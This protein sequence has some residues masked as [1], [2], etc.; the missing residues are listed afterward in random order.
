MESE[1]EQR[2][3]IQIHDIQQNTALNQQEKARALQQVMMGTYKPVIPSPT[4]IK[5]GCSHYRR[6]CLIKAPCC[7]QFFSCRHCHDEQVVG[8]RINRFEIKEMQCCFCSTVQP[9]SNQCTACL[10]KMAHYFCAICRLFDDD[11]QKVVWHCDHCGHCMIN[12]TDKPFQHCF[13]CNTCREK[14]HKEYAIIT[15]HHPP[16]TNNTT[17]GI[18]II[19]LVAIVPFV[20]KIS[21]I[22]YLRPIR[23]VGTGSTDIV[24]KNT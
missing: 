6:H 3:R 13:D 14:D 11:H 8:H 18:I 7:N 4:P 5:G 24:E 21:Q 1:R 2:M 23:R 22:V 10:Q 16:D 15:I 17:I 12:N 20:M 9:I 19:Q